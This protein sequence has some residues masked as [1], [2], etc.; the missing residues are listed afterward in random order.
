MLW[1]LREYTEES[2]IILSVSEEISIA[3]VAKMIAD[4]FGF[5]GKVLFDTSA[6]DGQF[7]KTVST[8]KLRGYLPSFQFT[9]VQEALCE[10]VEWFE[11]NWE[12]ARK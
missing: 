1:V 4:A 12:V 11:R 8:R 6:Q 3:A 7:R 10:T 5:Q 2:P 9:S